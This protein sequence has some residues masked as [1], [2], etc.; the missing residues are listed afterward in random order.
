M[1]TTS[2]TQSTPLPTVTQSTQT[3]QAQH[4]VAVS[5]PPA[6]TLYL[7]GDL[8]TFLVIVAV[9]IL[10]KVLMGSFGSADK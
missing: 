4:P 10:A 3:T 6:P 2:Q 5:Y 8:S 9:T 7:Q 1:S